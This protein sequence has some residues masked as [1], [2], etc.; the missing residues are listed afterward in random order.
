MARLP[1]PGSDSGNWGTLLNEYLSQAHKPDGLLKD[2]S[3]TAAAFAA[4]AVDSALSDTTIAARVA[5]AGA[6][7]SAVDV[8]VRSVGDSTYATAAQGAKADAAVRTVN[9]ASPD[10]S[11]NVTV[12]GTTVIT[13]EQYGAVG[14]GTTDD[15]A[16]L[17][18]MFNAAANKTILLSS[19]KSYRHTA[20]LTLSSNSVLM[21]G[22]GTLL[23]TNEQA[24]SLL[25]SGQHVT[26]DGVT[27][28]MS[29]STQRW[30]EY[31]KMK[32][33]VT[34]DYCTVR[35]VLIDGSAA[36][37]IYT[38]AQYF[39]YEGVH[40]RNTR[41]DGYYTTENSA[42]G[43]LI[44][45]TAENTGDDA[46]SVVSYSDQAVHDITN[47]GARVFG[48]S[49]RGMSVVGGQNVH[50]SGFQIRNTAGAGIYVA[51]EGSGY[52]TTSNVSVTSGQ[53]LSVNQNSG[54][55]HGA[56]HMTQWDAG[57][58]VTNVDISDISIRGVGQG[59][60]SNIRVIAY[61]NAI[62]NAMIRDISIF[63]GVASVYDTLNTGST[64]VI[65]NITM[66]GVEAAGT[67]LSV[68]VATAGITMEQTGLNVFSGSSAATWTLPSVSGD[69]GRIIR[70]K[71]RG[72]AT[73]T[74]QRAG[75]DQLYTTSAVT[76]T[77]VAA[78]AS[79]T[80][81]CDGT[82]WVTN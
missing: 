38:A 41:A 15:T 37:G 59:V 47:I 61:D 63:N 5:A 45:C 17:Q 44:G 64:V 33:R 16:A 21:T 8:R 18:A 51:S 71:N 54:I 46:F 26:L 40:V 72:S 25:V 24:S 48:S 67:R 49:A 53:L 4:G 78:G 10:G 68:L 43:R 50:Y 42:Y 6:V 7:R 73:L 82:Y 62:T 20:V 66:D 69:T 35:H 30:T 52:Y 31:E 32:L 14:D 76:S 60:S 22:G 77:T 36:S 12:T 19:G 1:Q 75:S 65:S 29:S 56:I 9:G 2:G 79:L 3:I 70:I 13:P 80:L 28:K 27:L 81:I 55:D 58:T 74:V 11:G 23:A 34:G 39:C 57:R